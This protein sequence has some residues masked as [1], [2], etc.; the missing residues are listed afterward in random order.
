MLDADAGCATG[1]LLRALANS[2]CDAYGA[3]ISE[4]AVTHQFA[5]QAGEMLRGIDTIA[6][7]R[8]PDI[9]TAA[10][11]AACSSPR[12]I[13]LR[14]VPGRSLVRDRRS[15]VPSETRPVPKFLVSGQLG[16]LPVNKLIVRGR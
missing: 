14:S 3:D 11:R 5:R 10:P 4:S 12:R 2:G 13:A 16:E 6:L 1:V 9:R 8:V 15:I 7:E